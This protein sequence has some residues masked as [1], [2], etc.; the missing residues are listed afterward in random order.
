ME[1]TTP[2]ANPGRVT[3]E[4]TTLRRIFAKLPDPTFLTRHHQRSNDLLRYAP[5]LAITDLL[6][7]RSVVVDVDS[8]HRDITWLYASSA[9][10]HI[11]SRDDVT[12]RTH[13][14][15]LLFL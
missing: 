7:A 10:H 5:L 4:K 12:V 6:N 8:P 3:R 13:P 9:F 15:W 1:D 11:R 14:S 2:I